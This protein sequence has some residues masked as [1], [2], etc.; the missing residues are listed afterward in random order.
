MCVPM[1][2]SVCPVLHMPGSWPAN[3]RHPWRTSDDVPSLA[4][5]VLHDAVELD[6]PVRQ[7]GSAEV[8]Q[9]GGPKDTPHRPGSSAH[10]QIHNT[11]AHLK[12]PA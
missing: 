9:L 12:H 11:A 5:E 2:S 4:A 10:L 1:R 7:P 3:H 8:V 6:A